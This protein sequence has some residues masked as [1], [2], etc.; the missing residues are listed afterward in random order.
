MRKPAYS[1]LLALGLAL[2]AAAP[3]AAAP[4]S[5]SQIVA[6]LNRERAHNGLYAHVTV[7]QGWSHDCALHNHY[8]A[9][10]HTLTHVEDRNAPAYTAGGAWAGLHSVL[11]VGATWRNGNPWETAPY[12]LLQVLDPGLRATGVAESESYNC[13]TTFPGTV[14]LH[15]A[16]DR[17]YSWPGNGRTDA[18]AFEQANELPTVPGSFV[19]LPAGR[20][21]GPNIM[22]YWAGPGGGSPD[23]LSLLSA[24]TLTDAHGRSVP[25][26]IVNS[27]R[28]STGLTQPTTGFVIPPKPLTAGMR[29]QLRATFRTG[30]GAPHPRSYTGTITFSTKRATPAAKLLRFGTPHIVGQ[31]VQFPWHVDPVLRNRRATCSFTYSAGFGI[32]PFGCTLYDGSSVGASIPA[33]GT[34]VT[35]IVRT[36]A[37]T[38]AGTHYGPLKFTKTYRR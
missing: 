11:A 28:D 8:M 9:V 38:Q 5:A 21:T 26:R 19:G 2:I 16:A 6:L 12:H 32:K 37:F 1:S 3:A 30:N 20:T 31:Y 29:Y 23:E 18:P 36:K 34:T 7:N 33:R 25:V 35:L 24:A 14:V 27:A 22:V 15:P 10:N 13:L 4:P 17:L